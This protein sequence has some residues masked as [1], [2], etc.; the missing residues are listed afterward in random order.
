MFLNTI[1]LMEYDM[2]SIDE[3]LVLVL[4][5]IVVLYVVISAY[6]VTSTIVM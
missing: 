4:A 6:L 3:V 5:V 1:Y 2:K